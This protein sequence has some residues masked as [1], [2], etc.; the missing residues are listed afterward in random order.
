LAGTYYLAACADANNTVVELNEI[1][2]CSFSKL[3][4]RQTIIVPMKK[5]TDANGKDEDDNDDEDEEYHHDD[6]DS[7]KDKHDWFKNPFGKAE[8]KR[9]RLKFKLKR[10]N[11]KWNKISISR[12]FAFRN[13]H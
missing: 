4:G 10:I 6:R 11:L 3:E 13:V 9:K 8:E 5:P 7:R 2:N 1:N 12:V